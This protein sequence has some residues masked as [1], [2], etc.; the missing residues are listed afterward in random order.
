MNF[1]FIELGAEG[2][3]DFGSSRDVSLAGDNREL[4]GESPVEVANSGFFGRDTENG[5]LDD[6]NLGSRFSEPGA[7]L[8]QVA[9]LKALVINNDK[10]GRTIEPSQIFF[11]EMFLFRT[12]FLK[13]F[14]N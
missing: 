14:K 4:A 7:K 6:V 8:A 11:S 9:N 2:F 12:H 1:Q 3:D 13:K 10:K 5:I